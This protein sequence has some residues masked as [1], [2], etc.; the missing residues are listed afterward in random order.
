MNFKLN[1]WTLLFLFALGALA[2]FYVKTKSIE[3]LDKILKIKN[4]YSITKDDF[5]KEKQQYCDRYVSVVRD[6]ALGLT[7]K[8][9]VDTMGITAY[10]LKQYELEVMY[11]YFVSID[12][13]P[14]KKPMVYVYPII[15]DST[16][17]GNVLKSEFDLV[18]LIRTE[19]GTEED[20]FDFTEPCPPVCEENKVPYNNCFYPN[21]N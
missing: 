16:V 5:I 10:K 18:F 3:D 12:N 19:D 11:N 7:K 14:H 2:Y 8:V 13:T 17:N 20:F 6:P 21:I 9:G 1:L 15:K 4:A